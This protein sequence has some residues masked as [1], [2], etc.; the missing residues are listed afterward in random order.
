MT[1][2]YRVASSATVPKTVGISIPAVLFLFAKKIMN[3]NA[4]KSDVRVCNW[5]GQHHPGGVEDNSLAP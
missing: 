3:M 2:K 4:I 1:R 5:Q